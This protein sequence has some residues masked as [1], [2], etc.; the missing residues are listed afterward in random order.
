MNFFMSILGLVAA[1]VFVVAGLSFVF[2]PNA[3]KRLLALAASRLGVLFAMAIVLSELIR[4]H[5]AGIVI[6]LL[7]V[8]PVAYFVR[9][10]RRPHAAR[11]QKVC[12]RER[13]PIAPRPIR[14]DER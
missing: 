5:P 10:R 11:P 14:E 7:L 12:G 4:M 1:I 13:M 8:S 2:N 6:G 3:A 9:E